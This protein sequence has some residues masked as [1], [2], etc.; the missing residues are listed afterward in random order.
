MSDALI[1]DG[2][3]CP[4]CMK[5]TLRRGIQRVT[6]EYQGRVFEEDQPGDWCDACGEG[7]LNGEDLEAT[8]PAWLAFREQVDR[9]QGRN[10]A[11]IRRKLKLTQIEAARL[12]GGAKHSFSQY[13]RGVVRPTPA[14]VNLFKLLDKHPEMLRDLKS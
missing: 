1:S 5:G 7:I 14:V 8:E 13:E 12:T 6:M 4:V 9:E 11:R 10:L 2:K 3:P